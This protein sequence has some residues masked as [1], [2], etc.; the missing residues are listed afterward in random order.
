MRKRIQTYMKET[1]DFVDRDYY[2]WLKK[3]ISICSIQTLCIYDREYTYNIIYRVC[4]HGYI[5]NRFL[6]REVF[7]PIIEPRYRTNNDARNCLCS[8]CYGSAVFWKSPIR[9]HLSLLF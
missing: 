5:G 9:E 3:H 2:D 6:C 8:D 1:A 4:W 7:A